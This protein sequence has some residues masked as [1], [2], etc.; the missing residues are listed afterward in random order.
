MVAGEAR[1]SQYK[2]LKRV[3]AAQITYVSRDDNAGDLIK[4]DARNSSIGD[5]V[6]VLLEPRVMRTKNVVA[7][8]YTRL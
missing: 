4:A 3:M 7:K 6:K 1:E 8:V 5:H 2:W